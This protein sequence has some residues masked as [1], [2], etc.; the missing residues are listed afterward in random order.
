[1]GYWSKAL[2]SLIFSPRGKVQHINKIGISPSS[3][4]NNAK[5]ME[6]SYHNNQCQ[7]Q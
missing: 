2:K 7:K 3:E 5:P 4:L 1:M 6:H